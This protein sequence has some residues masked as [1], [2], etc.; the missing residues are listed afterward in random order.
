MSKLKPLTRE[1]KILRH[2]MTIKMKRNTSDF[3]RLMGT[4]CVCTSVHV[5][6]CVG[7]HKLVHVDL[8]LTRGQAGGSSHQSPPCIKAGHVVKNVDSFKDHGAHTYC[9]S[10]SRKC[11]CAHTHTHIHSHAHTVMLGSRLG[12]SDDP[13]MS[14]KRS[15]GPT[16]LFRGPQSLRIF[17]KE[18]HSNSSRGVCVCVQRNGEEKKSGMGNNPTEEVCLQTVSSGNPLHFLS[19]TFSSQTLASSSA[20]PAMLQ[21]LHS[22]HPARSFTQN[23]RNVQLSQCKNIAES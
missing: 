18:S 7:A 3:L 13:D 10:L 5:C 21:T 8:A 22:P 20:T 16:A 9:V 14:G 19:M 4:V 2:F 11:A 6:V 15:Q 12:R 17:H 1:K 23:L